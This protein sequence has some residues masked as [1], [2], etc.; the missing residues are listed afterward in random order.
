MN[1]RKD[2]RYNQGCEEDKIEMCRPHSW[3]N[4]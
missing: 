3:T 1:S 2:R 4:R